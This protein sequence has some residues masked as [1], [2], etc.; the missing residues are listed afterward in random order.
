MFS[1]NWLRLWFFWF[2]F[3]FFL[4]IFFHLVLFVFFILFIFFVIFIIFILVLFIIFIIIVKFWIL[5][6]WKIFIFSNQIIMFRATCWK[7]INPILIF[8][9]WRSLI[10]TDNHESR[11]T[12]TTRVAFQL[13]ILILRYVFNNFIWNHYF[14]WFNFLFS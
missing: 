5:L 3:W 4:I 1:N 14:L 6:R 8:S 9:F 2:R 10:Y 12:F 11:I 7:A 13:L